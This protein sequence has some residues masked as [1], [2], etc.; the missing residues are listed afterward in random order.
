MAAHGWYKG[1]HLRFWAPHVAA[2]GAVLPG[3]G[4]AGR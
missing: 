3:Q 4:T 2:T 1:R